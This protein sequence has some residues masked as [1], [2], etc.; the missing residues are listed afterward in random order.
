MRAL[1]YD[2][3]TAQNTN[4]GSICAV[5]W[6]LLENDVIKEEGYSLINPQ[7]TFSKINAKI[8]GIHANDVQDAPCFADYW[9][10]TLKELMTTSLVIAHNAHFDISATEQALYNSHIEDPG[11]HY[12][13]SMPLFKRLI[14]ASSYQLQQLAALTHFEYHI[15]NA[16]EDTHALLHVL[17]SVRDLCGFEDI[18]SMIIR[19]TVRAANSQTNGYVPKQIPK[20]STQIPAYSHCE[21]EV[22][23]L[24]TCLQGLRF[25]ITGEI[26]GYERSDMER[27]IFEHGGKPTSGVSRK[28]D[29]LI[30]GTYSD[31]I[32]GIPTMTSKHKKALEIMNQGG[33]IHIISPESFF[34]MIHK[35]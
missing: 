25:C 1:I 24:D 33:K 29:Y 2:V 27:M 12:I 14:K 17:F 30:V 3:E 11:I 9:N 5:G 16:K 35:A 32:S 28:T 19:T 10:S 21:E 13:D 6:I 20:K 18:A 15:H 26:A 23:V 4:I 34:A 31:P 8:H 22:K 7:C